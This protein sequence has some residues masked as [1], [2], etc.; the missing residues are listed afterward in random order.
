MWKKTEFYLNSDVNL[1]RVDDCFVIAIFAN[2][3][4]LTAQLKQNITCFYAISLQKNN[5]KD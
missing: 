2:E 4:F 5:L 3:A 1:K